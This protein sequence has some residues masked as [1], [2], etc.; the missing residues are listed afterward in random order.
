VIQSS[1]PL[2]RNEDLKP[3]SKIIY[4]FPAYVEVRKN[5]RKNHRGSFILRYISCFLTIEK[6]FA[7]KI[8]TKEKEF[9][10]SSPE[11][12]EFI[13]PYTLYKQIK[14]KENRES[15]SVLSEIFINPKMYTTIKKTFYKTKNI[16]EEYSYIEQ[17]L[18]QTDL[19]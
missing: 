5:L 14:N 12:P 3:G 15:F 17:I 8:M 7:N 10:L 19:F 1:N 2:F 4:F 18:M 9:Y 16:K 13:I 6:S 11:L